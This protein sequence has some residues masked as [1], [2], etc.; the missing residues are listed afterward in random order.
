M[1]VRRAIANGNWSSPSTWFGGALPTNGDTVAANGFTVIIDQDVTIGG[2]NN[3][4]VNAGSFVTGQW[5]QITSIGTTIFTSAGAG[6]NAVGVIFQATGAG[7]GTGVATE[8]ATLTTAAIAAASAVAGGGFTITTAFTLAADIRAGTTPCLTVTGSGNATYTSLNLIGGPQNNAIALQNNSTGTLS[9]V[10]CTCNG[11][12]TTNAFSVN[13]ASTGSVVANNCTATGGIAGSS[14]AIVNGS[15]GSITATSCNFTGGSSN[16][17]FGLINLSTGSITVNSCN[18]TAS[19]TF[20]N[21]GLSGG[22][23]TA[24]S[25]NFTGGGGGSSVAYSHTGTLNVSLTLCTFTAGAGLGAHAFSGSNTGATP[26]ISGSQFDSANGTAAVYCVRYRIGTTPSLMQYRKALD[27]TST[28][29]TLFTP[30]FGVF[31]NPSPAN[32]RTGVSYGDGSLTGT[33]A[34][35]PAGSVALGVPVDATTGT[36]VLTM[37]AVQNAVI[38]LV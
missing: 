36:A 35:P 13:N 34:I 14:H 5:Y 6:S 31:G 23:V 30:D 21:V 19:G 38:P 37:Q 29:M 25:C 33:A 11:G 28:F 22:N 26:I 17:A 10:L 27:G 1:P 9:L 8:L 7:S 18:F 2:A 16:A 12:G 4:S 20:G 24:T 3:P 32:V 15:T